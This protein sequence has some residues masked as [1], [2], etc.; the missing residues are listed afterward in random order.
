MKTIISSFIILNIIGF[1]LAQQTVLWTRFSDRECRTKGPSPTDQGVA[2]PLIIPVN[3][4][5]LW[6][7]IPGNLQYIKFGACKSSSEG[8][9]YLIF[10]DKAVCDAA[11]ASQLT[12]QLVMGTCG[13]R[14]DG[15]SIQAT[16]SSASTISFSLLFAV[17]SLLA[18]C[19]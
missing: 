11:T 15:G 2:N 6:N 9:P 5:V 12:A 4:C 14:G 10:A 3:T 18:F 17:A 13:I 8:S 19:L 1:A 7:N 16:C